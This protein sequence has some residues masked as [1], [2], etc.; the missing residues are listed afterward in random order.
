MHVVELDRDLVARLEKLSP[1][2]LT[3]TRAMR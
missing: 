3:S 2:K 1:A